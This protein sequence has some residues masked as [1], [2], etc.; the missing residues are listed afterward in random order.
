MKGN[1]FSQG[2]CWEYLAGE[3]GPGGEVR[4]VCYLGKVTGEVET[5]TLGTVLPPTAQTWQLI[6]PWANVCIGPTC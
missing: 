1:T 2:T 4:P 3:S 6:H 5:I